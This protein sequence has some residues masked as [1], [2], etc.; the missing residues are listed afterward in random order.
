VK[1][2][3]ATAL[4]SVLAPLAV[5]LFRDEA[6]GDF[7]SYIDSS[8]AP[9]NS[10]APCELVGALPVDG[11]SVQADAGPTDGRLVQS[12]R[13]ETGLSGSYA[14][15]GPAMGGFKIEGVTLKG[16]V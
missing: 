5:P 11:S 10:P 3:T 14:W 1:P 16:E 15:A 9:G 6:S 2:V 12:G 13:P 7:H 8:R 4:G